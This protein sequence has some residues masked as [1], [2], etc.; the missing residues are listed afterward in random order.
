MSKAAA[1]LATRLCKD[2]AEM[3]CQRGGPTVVETEQIQ[4][5]LQAAD[6]GIFPLEIVGV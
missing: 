2:F 3:R 5:L 4:H 6:F 1:T